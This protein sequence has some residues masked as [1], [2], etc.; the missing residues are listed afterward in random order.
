MKISLNWL[1][2]LCDLPNE[3]AENIGEKITLHTAELEEVISVQNGFERVFAGKLIRT[4]PHPTSDKLS[5]GQFDLGKVGTKQIIYGQVHPLTIGKV[6]PIAL[7]GAILPTGQAIKN[8]IIREQ[9]SEGMVCDNSELGMK[10]AEL[11]TFSEDQIGKT[12][13]E[14]C[15]EFADKLFDIDN[16]SLT[17]RPDLMGHRGF[18]REYSAI[19]D[20]DKKSADFSEQ[21]FSLGNETITVDIQTSNCRRFMAA[22]VKN[23]QV[24]PSPL[25]EIVRLE[26]LGT[27]AISNI[28]DITNLVMLEHGQPMHAFDAKKIRG[29]IIIRQAQAGEKL[30]ALDDNEYELTADDI[31]IADEEKILSIAGIMG[32]AESAVTNDTTEIIFESANFDPAV[33]R[34]TS[35]RLGLRSESSMRFEKSLDPENCKNGILAAL[36]RTQSILPNTE[37]TSHIADNYAQ[38]LETKTIK[39]PL[40]R[41][42]TLSGL[43]IQDTEIERILTALEFKITKKSAD[44]FEV[45]IPSFRATK[46]VAIAEDLIEEVVRQYGFEN[47]PE[48]VPNLPITL[49]RKNQLRNL[50]WSL[51]DFFAT[52]NYLEVYHTSFVAPTDPDFIE[53]DDH[54]SMINSTNEETQYLR[55]TLAS[56]LVRN[57]ENELRTHGKINFFE[58]GKVYTQPTNERQVLGILSAELQGNGENLFYQLKKDLWQLFSDLGVEATAAPVEKPTALQ[59]PYRSAEIAINGVVIG[60]IFELFPSKN[61]TKNSVAVYAEIDLEKL[62]PETQSVETKYQKICEYPVSTRDL[63]IV[64]DEKVLIADIQATAK[65]SADFLISISLFDE[66]RDEQKLGKNLKNLAFHLSFQ[67][68]DGTLSHEEIEK[69]FNSIVTALQKTHS[70]QLRVDFDAKKC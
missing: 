49:P 46:D 4:A 61:T 63:S 44:F 42:R 6:Y 57:M 39:L 62:L 31:V 70:A 38:K 8:G 68:K 23:V 9:K 28:V 14:I 64:L 5:I 33:I 65:K 37:I 27:R 21:D 50:E 29:K 43:D 66:Y 52:K 35:A 18:A 3:T 15:N 55:Q 45:E 24:Q 19:Y 1:R 40:N 22:K 12:L 69:D 41:V 48:T 60:E 67:S 16:K 34:K 2:E 25:K 20:V 47:I 58:I 54:V 56:N 51:R 53:K 7:D 32:G 36:K 26:N 17:H 59:H 13:P 30:V 10:N 11:L